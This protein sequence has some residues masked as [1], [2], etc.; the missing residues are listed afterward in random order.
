MCSLTE[1]AFITNPV[2]TVLTMQTNILTQKTH[3][4]KHSESYLPRNFQLSIVREPIAHGCFQ[5]GNNQVTVEFGKPNCQ[6]LTS[7]KDCSSLELALHE[8][9]QR[10]G[11]PRDTPWVIHLVLLY[12]HLSPDYHE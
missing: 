7:Q 2:A 4:A 1:L 5:A 10:L 8:F 12:A 9:I 6:P 3:C 11:P